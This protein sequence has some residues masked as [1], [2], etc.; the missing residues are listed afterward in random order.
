MA[1]CNINWGQISVE[2]RTEDTRFDH[3]L[4]T[5]DILGKLLTGVMSEPIKQVKEAV[6]TGNISESFAA[7]MN[8]T[9][10]MRTPLFDGIDPKHEDAGYIVRARAIAMQTFHDELKS[11]TDIINK[12]KMK[13]SKDKSKRGGTVLDEKSEL[14]LIDPDT[15]LPKVTSLTIHATIGKKL[16]SSLGLTPRTKTDPK[17]GKN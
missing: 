6:R 12:L 16:A 9:G 17:T 8:K 5:D 3:L 1:E 10:A 7:V 13:A 4:V 15:G 2:K 11:S 14:L